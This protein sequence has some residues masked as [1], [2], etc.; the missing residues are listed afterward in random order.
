[1]SCFRPKYVTFDCY[2]TLTNFEMAEAARD[3]YG[4]ILSDAAMAEFIRIFAAYRLDEILGAW[5]PYAEVIRNALE[6]SCRKTGVAFSVEDAEVIYRRVPTWGPHPDAG[7]SR[8]GGEGNSARHSLQCDDGTDPVERGQA[9][10][11]VPRRLHGRAGTGLQ[12]SDAGV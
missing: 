6:R 9:G 11:A 10:R 2:G 5:K 3:L 7:W 8:Q 12:T 4:A 1:M